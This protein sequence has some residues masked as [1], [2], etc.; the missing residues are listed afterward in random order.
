[1]AVRLPWPIYHKLKESGDPI[2]GQIVKIVAE[3]LAR[4]EQTRCAVVA[5]SRIPTL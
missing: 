1:M 4:R 5:N 3:E 2:A